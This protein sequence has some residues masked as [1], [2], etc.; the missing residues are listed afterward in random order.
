MQDQCRRVYVGLIILS[1][2]VFVRGIR[3]DD[4]PQFRG[5][6][7]DSVWRETGILT[8]FPAKG[9][10]VRWRAAVGFGWSSPVVANGR[11]YL[12]DSELN[13]HK[14]KERVHCFDEATGKQLWTFSYDVAYP[15]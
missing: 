8:S 7:R 6:N 3:A 12:T 10:K 4:W 15:E 13:K 5:P 11:V 14:A 1:A 9:L 2:L